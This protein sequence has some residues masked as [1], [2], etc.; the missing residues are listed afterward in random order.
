MKFALLSDVGRIRKINE[1]YIAQL[2]VSPN[3][4]LFLLADGMGGHKKGEVASRL[5]VTSIKKYFEKHVRELENIEA[6]RDERA[7]FDFLKR[8]IVFS[9][10]KVYKMS[11]RSESMND[12]G[13]TLVV[14]LVFFKKIIIANIG[15]S[16]AYLFKENELSQITIDNS[17]V[18]ELVNLGIITKEEAKTHAQ[19]NMITRAVGIEAH[20]EADFYE[21][22]VIKDTIVLMCSDGLSNMLDDDKLCDILNQFYSPGFACG[23]FVKEAN[24]A[25]GYD[26]ISVVCVYF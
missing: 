6:E 5:A 14:M 23:K 17:Y 9:N 24:L 4:H 1:D 22:P 26:N 11:K 20:M 8:S 16:R 10:T 12:M 19:K 7:V 18:Q 25:G 3:L 21:L 2:T 15:D 13:T